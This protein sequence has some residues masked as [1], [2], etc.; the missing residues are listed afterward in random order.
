MPQSQNDNGFF[1]KARLHND[2]V[3]P[4]LTHCCERRLNFL[5]SVN[6]DRGDLQAQ[7]RGGPLG[8]GD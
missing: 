3:D 8:F 6:Q 5:I 4:L 7:A 2:G 1:R